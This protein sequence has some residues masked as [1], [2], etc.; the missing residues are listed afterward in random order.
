MAVCTCWRLLPDGT[1]ESRC[2][3]AGLTAQEVVA[4]SQTGDHLTRPAGDNMIVVDPT[5]GH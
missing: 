2:V 5:H 4:A 3:Y 1:H